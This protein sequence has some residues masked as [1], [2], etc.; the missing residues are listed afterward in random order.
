MERRVLP[1]RYTSSVNELNLGYL[2]VID[3]QPL[4]S[5]LLRVIAKETKGMWLVAYIKTNKVVTRVWGTT[6]Q[7]WDALRTQWNYLDQH[8]LFEADAKFHFW[9]SELKFKLE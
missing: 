7:L 8:G 4:S 1:E 5:S 2:P 9:L 6:K 3:R